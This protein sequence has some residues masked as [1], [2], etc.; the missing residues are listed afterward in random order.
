MIEN[1]RHE[2]EPQLESMDRMPTLPTVL[3][4][5]L[6]HLDQPVEKMDVNRVVD[7]IG[8]DKSL[9]VQCL[10]LANSPLF[11]HSR[12]IDTVRT[13]VVSL[14][15]RRVR[16]IALSCCILRLM[17]DKHQLQNPVVFWEHAL[18]CALVSRQFAQQ[19]R[20]PEPERAYLGGLLHDLGL[21]V[22]LWIMPEKFRL[23]LE[24]ATRE[25][26]PLHEAEEE[27]LG[28]THEES[29][30]LLAAHW[31][32]GPELQEVIGFHHSVT[33]AKNHRAL[34]AIVSLSDLLCRMSTL[35]YG[36]A[37]ERE[38][39][40]TELPGFETLLKACPHL[41]RFD[42]ARFTMEMD[43]YLPEVRRLVTL[44]FRSH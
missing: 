20:F 43:A 22:N 3:F 30:A 14:G 39:C 38:V 27:I 16:E 31:G 12:S 7:W 28:F 36:Y 4:P 1:A 34:V 23:A 17:P 37:E 9:T 32:L 44:L 11:S 33:E 24:K 40:L 2:I 21:V 35:G 5:L 29:G 25:R 26:I 6:R 10:H 13:A 18:G 42:W 19:I 8:K 15:M 41:E